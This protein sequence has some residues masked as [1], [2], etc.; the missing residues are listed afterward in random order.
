MVPRN[1]GG[2]GAGQEDGALMTMPRAVPSAQGEGRT[3]D[4]GPGAGSVRHP[5]HDRPGL[6]RLDATFTLPDTVACGE[7]RPL[8]D[9]ASASDMPA[10]PG[11]GEVFCGAPASKPPEAEHLPSPLGGRPAHVPTDAIRREVEINGAALIPQEHIAALVGNIQEDPAQALPGGV[12]PRRRPR[13]R[14]GG[15]GTVQADRGGQR[16]GVGARSA[17]NRT[18]GRHSVVLHGLALWDISPA[19]N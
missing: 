13:L 8:R 6:G 19:V 12:G 1:T 9:P 3:A 16:E 14:P 15:D 4:P 11:A 10:N 2:P 7:L 17:R 5:R 18:L